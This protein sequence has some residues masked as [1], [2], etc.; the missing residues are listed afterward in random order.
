MEK[1]LGY[2]PTPEEAERMAREKAETHRLDRQDIQQ[3]E[4][5]GN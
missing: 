2:I 4:K 5:I 3:R 1:I